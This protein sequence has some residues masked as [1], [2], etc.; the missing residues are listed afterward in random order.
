MLAGLV[1]FRWHQYPPNNEIIMK[2]RN[3]TSCEYC[4]HLDKFSLLPAIQKNYQIPYDQYRHTDIRI[5]HEV[6]CN[7]ST[8]QAWIHP[9]KYP[10]TSFE[11]IRCQAYVAQFHF[12]LGMDAPKSIQL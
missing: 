10:V 6:P 12:N 7:V 4:Q 11:G 9:P 1:G 5:I 3:E 2:H 8:W